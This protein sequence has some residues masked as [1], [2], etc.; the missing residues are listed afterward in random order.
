[1]VTTARCECSSESQTADHLTTECLLYSPTQESV[2]SIRLDE[3]PTVW[4]QKTCPDIG[5]EA[6]MTER[7]MSG[8]CFRSGY[9]RL[10]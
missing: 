10:D 3:D 2:S 5:R 1:M 6:Q 8:T 9:V 4:L 7:T